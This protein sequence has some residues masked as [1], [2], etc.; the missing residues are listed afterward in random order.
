MLER[1]DKQGS[2]YLEYLSKIFFTPKTGTKAVLLTHPDSVPGPCDKP[3]RP[4][5][6]VSHYPEA[7]LGQNVRKSGKC[8][9][10]ELS[11]R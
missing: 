9:W 11:K 8:Q 5:L 3:F 10:D 2:L 7:L 1:R 6:K 4:F